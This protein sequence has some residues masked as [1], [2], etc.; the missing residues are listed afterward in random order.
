MSIKQTPRTFSL[1]TDALIAST[2]RN[3]E[4]NNTRIVLMLRKLKQTNNNFLITV[5]AREV[6]I[7]DRKPEMDSIYVRVTFS[8]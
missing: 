1:A 4:S 3:N 8:I 2:F 5:V 6:D 7:N